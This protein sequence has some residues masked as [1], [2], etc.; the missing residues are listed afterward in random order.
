MCEFNEWGADKEAL[1]G[2]I[3]V[4]VKLDSHATSHIFWESLCCT[5]LDG[6]V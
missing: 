3:Y 5:Q 4:C 1:G 2:G 6:Y